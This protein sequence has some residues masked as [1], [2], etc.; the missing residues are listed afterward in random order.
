MKSMSHGPKPLHEV[1]KIISVDCSGGDVSPR[2]SWKD[3]FPEAPRKI[4]SYSDYVKATKKIGK[5][6]MSES[7]FEQLMAEKI[8]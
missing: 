1:L 2:R 4:W 3:F 7:E 5:E 8:L 6:P